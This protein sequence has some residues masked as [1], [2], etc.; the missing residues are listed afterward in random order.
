M[1]GKDK[2]PQG[3]HK[4]PS[5]LHDDTHQLTCTTGLDTDQFPVFLV[6]YPFRPPCS[7]TTIQPSF[8]WSSQVAKILFTSWKQAPACLNWFLELVDFRIKCIAKRHQ[9]GVFG[10]GLISQHFSLYIRNS[11]QV[12]VSSCV[13]LN[14]TKS[15]LPLLSSPRTLTLFPSSSQKQLILVQ[16]SALWSVPLFYYLQ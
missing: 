2:R 9:T 11:S 1:E 14:K 15:F 6:S 4:Q 5:C 3:K 12:F 16:I 13:H 8:L 7:L 10:S